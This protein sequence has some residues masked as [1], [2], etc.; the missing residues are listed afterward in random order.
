VV[1]I[2]A[3]KSKASNL[4]KLRCKMNNEFLCCILDSKVT[5]LFMIS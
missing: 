2:R 1:K 5:N 4:L 3:N